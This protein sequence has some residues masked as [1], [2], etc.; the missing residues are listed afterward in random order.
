MMQK[1]IIDFLDY[2][3][4]FEHVVCLQSLGFRERYLMFATVLRALSHWSRFSYNGLIEGD[5][6][7]PKEYYEHEYFETVESF[8]DRAP[9]N[10]DDEADVHELFSALERELI[11][12]LSFAADFEN[13]NAY[14]SLIDGDDNIHIPEYSFLVYVQEKNRL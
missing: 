3:K 1:V 10:K 12:A 14:I 6:G 4:H 7:H 9:D 2:Y 13:R 8:V 11:A 5:A